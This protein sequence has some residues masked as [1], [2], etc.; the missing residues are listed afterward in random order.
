[1]VAWL[2]DEMASTTGLKLGEITIFS[3]GGNLRPRFGREY[4]NPDKVAMLYRYRFTIWNF[5]RSCEREL[6]AWCDENCLRKTEIVVILTDVDTW[7]CICAFEKKIDCVG[8][9]LWW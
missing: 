7:A 2:P 8:F 1:M 3:S 4:K 6:R 5:D 9:K